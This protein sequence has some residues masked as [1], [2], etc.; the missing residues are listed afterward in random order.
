MTTEVMEKMLEAK[1]PEWV[2]ANFDALRNGN[3][4]LGAVPKMGEEMLLLKP[5]DSA[6]ECFAAVNVG[7]VCEEP[8]LTSGGISGIGYTV[9]CD[10]FP[11][12]APNGSSSEKRKK[13]TFP[14]AE[15][16]IPDSHR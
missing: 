6:G 13:I 1:S 15:G 8:M 5:Q 2:K 16:I 7:R 14:L 4:I 11:K 3:Y 12:D 10:T 9:A